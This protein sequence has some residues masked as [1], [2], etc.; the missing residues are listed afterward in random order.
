MRLFCVANSSGNKKVPRSKKSR[1]EQRQNFS[2]IGLACIHPFLHPNLSSCG[3]FW[4][5]ATSTTT[6]TTSQWSLHHSH[7]LLHLDP[8]KAMFNPFRFPSRS[9]KK[10][11]TTDRGG[12]SFQRSKGR[13][14]SSSTG[15]R[16][17][18]T[19]TYNAM[20]HD[21]APYDCRS[22]APSP[23]EKKIQPLFSP[24]VVDFSSDDDDDD[25]D[26]SI[27]THSS[28]AA[29]C[30]NRKRKGRNRRASVAN[31][32][33]NQRHNAKHPRLDDESLTAPSL[34]SN[35]SHSGRFQ[36]IL[37]RPFPHWQQ[38]N[39]V[40]KEVH[41]SWS[42]YQ[43]GRMSHHLIHFLELKVGINEYVPTGLLLPSPVVEQAWKA[44]VLETSL[45]FDVTYA[46]QDFHG[47]DRAMI[48]YTF[49]SNRK[50]STKE[51]DDKLRRTQS[52]FHVY[53]KEPMPLTILDEPQEPPAS[54]GM[55]HPQHSRA[56]TTPVF[57]SS[58]PDKR[59]KDSIFEFSYL[60]IQSPT[61]VSL[62][63]FSSPSA[64]LFST[65]ASSKAD[66][67]SATAETQSIYSSSVAGSSGGLMGL[68]LVD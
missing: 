52:L 48:H 12:Y 1:P 16:P 36:S 37:D 21:D 49:L 32:N 61:K 45:Y 22:I 28:S 26:S 55:G 40:L 35:A 9:T 68:G 41:P 30:A 46:I 14:T 66:S 6:T 31:H 44:L 13:R 62:S 23:K 65:P 56:P 67:S 64:T 63:S 50:L 8:A 54:H 19:C 38:L 57:S 59:N 47:K 29:E 18:A 60:S 33:H 24:S 3:L 39:S 25:D 10:D 5:V 53:F 15:H 43:R 2:F 20:S 51:A 4:R 27:S 17:L 11:G 7:Q 34:T 42:P 58:S